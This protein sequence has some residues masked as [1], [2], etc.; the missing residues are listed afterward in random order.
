MYRFS[1][2]HTGCIRFGSLKKN[3]I[4]NV[5][6]GILVHDRTAYKPLCAFQN[7]N[8]A[9]I[10]YACGS[11]RIMITEEAGYVKI[12]LL[13]VP[14]GSDGFIFGPYETDADAFGEI[15][16]AA[17]YDDGSVIC[18]QSLM[19]KVVE[20]AS[21][22]VENNESGISFDGLSRAAVSRD[23]KV[24]LQVSAIDMSR[25]VKRPD[26]F[27]VKPVRDGD[28]S[29]CG[30][31]VALLYAESAEELLDLI[32][33]MELAEKL[34]HPLYETNYA[35]KDPRCSSPYI[36]FQG[37]DINKDQLMEL[38]CRARV[39]CIYF[40]NMFT[41]WG[42]FAL[43]ESEFPNGAA[44]IR[45]YADQAAKKN[46]IIGAHSLSNFIT[47][48]DEYITP[49]PHPNLQIRDTTVLTAAISE[50]DTEIY[51]AEAMN[52]GN[53]STLNTFRIGNE[54]IRFGEFDAGK[55]CLKKC[56]RGA[57][58]TVAVC[59]NAGDK[60]CRLCDHGYGTFFPDID[61]QDEIAD[62]LGNILRDCGI[63]KLS[64]DGLEGCDETGYPE[65]ARNRFA[66]RIYDAVGNRLLCDGSNISHYL[67]HIFSYCNWGEPWYDHKRRGG[68]HT[69]RYLNTV[70]LKRNL[71]PPMMGWY[72]IFTNKGRYEATSPQNMEYMLSRNVAFGA[73]S[74][75]T[76]SAQVAKNHGLISQYMDM[77]RIWDRFRLEGDI[78]E[79][80]YTYLQEEMTDWHLEET[81]DGWILTQLLL[82]E[83]DLAYGD[84]VIETEAGH[85]GARSVSC[86]GALVRHYS[87][88]PLDAPYPEFYPEPLHIRI[89]VG[90]PGHGSLSDLELYG[91]LS[92]DVHADG[93]DYLEYNGGM[94]LY[95]YD[96]NFNLLETVIGKGTPIRFGETLP[97]TRHGFAWG[98]IRYTTDKDPEAKYM[99]VEIRKRRQFK[100]SRKQVNNAN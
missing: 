28:A 12:T 2:E 51:V 8:E 74:A 5:H 92:F 27:V 72:R 4:D 20:G 69:Y 48:N 22:P 46:V 84:R 45:G 81:K 62:N 67:W 82:R 65:Y 40:G 100:I 38:A 11:C 58:G 44:D 61:L 31:A 6:I 76:I 79:E 16:G 90:E 32:G 33:E 50:D 35:K 39:S 54:L 14:E 99:M 59:H 98:G 80:A 60:V 21:V 42:H 83:Q 56:E 43:K 55:L 63:L 97:A 71:L 91:A 86:G 77:I 68:M 25:E 9:E 3:C 13:S 17:W 64:L 29:L 75:F 23:G 70:Y 57:F 53:C 24:H 37:S 66:K 95:R 73:G 36:V 85:I 93:G 10:R 49:I 78:P 52:Y 96:C 88:Y 30:A 7:G 89:R 19:P 15:L 94:E 41:K 18:V 26:G 34:P 1:L 87:T 47:T